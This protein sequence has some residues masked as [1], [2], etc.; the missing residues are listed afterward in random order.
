MVTISNRCKFLVSYERMY[1]WCDYLIYQYVFFV[2]SSINVGSYDPRSGPTIHDPTYLPQSYI[3]SRF[4]TTFF[5]PHILISV[6]I[7]KYKK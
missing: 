1:N 4:L 6:Y 3:G 2:F 7:K 5:K